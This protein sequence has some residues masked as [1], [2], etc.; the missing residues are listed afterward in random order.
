MMNKPT[1][2]R[3][4]RITLAFAMITSGMIAL[5]AP[6]A[7]AT[8]DRPHTVHVVTA[9]EPTAA[10]RKAMRVCAPARAK[11]ESACHSLYLRP[12]IA[13][14]PAGRV[15]VAECIG[16]AE[17]EGEEWG[18]AWGLTYLGDCFRGNIETP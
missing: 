6:N 8:S 3:F 2:K 5:W 4:P 14:I 15:I 18:K 7:Q 1:R 10:M 9:P 16:A 11:D 17:L 13:D 12:K